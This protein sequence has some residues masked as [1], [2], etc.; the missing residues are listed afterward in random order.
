MAIRFPVV[1]YPE[2]DVIS[3]RIAAKLALYFI[4]GGNDKG[5]L[6]EIATALE[7]RR[8]QTPYYAESAKIVRSSDISRKP[9]EQSITWGGFEIDFRFDYNY[10]GTAVPMMVDAKSGQADTDSGQLGRYVRAINDTRAPNQIWGIGIAY[11]CETKKEKSVSAMWGKHWDLFA[12]MVEALSGLSPNQPGQAWANGVVQSAEYKRANPKSDYFRNLIL[13]EQIR[14]EQSGEEGWL[15]AMNDLLIRRANLILRAFWVQSIDE[16][17][18][19]SMLKYESAAAL[20]ETWQRW[21]HEVSLSHVPHNLN[22]RYQTVMDQL[23]GS[24]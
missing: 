5:E 11:S 6:Q 21:K 9:L 7:F 2:N 20:I 17:M 24:H 4:S 3:N 14:L 22:S 23:R 10:Q 16:S 13:A 15:K 19:L 8:G 1:Q 18:A 12:P